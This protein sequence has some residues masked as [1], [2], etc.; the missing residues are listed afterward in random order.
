[1]IR[2]HTDGACA[3]NPG[4]GGWAWVNLDART[5][6]S[7]GAEHTT[8]QRMEVQAA[9]E[10][11]ISHPGCRLRIVSDSKYV[12]D[13]FNQS[14][15]EG[16]MKRG[17]KRAGNKEVMNLDLWRPFIELVLARGDTDFEWV[18]GH[19]G[20]PGNEAADIA[21]VAAVPVLAKRMQYR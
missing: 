2:V 9:Y 17:W 3:G 10:A 11:V 15:Y 16:W 8:N 21:A 5:S 20:D 19:S 14:W 13:C 7:G 12:V 1:M 4:P 18:K 6:A